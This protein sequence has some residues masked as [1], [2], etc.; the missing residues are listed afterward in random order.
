MR[1]RRAVDGDWRA[2]RE[3]RLEAL[4][5]APLAFASTYAREAAFSDEVWRGRIAG[6]AQFL[7]LVGDE[8]VGTATGY[9]DE[10]D[11]H[12]VRLV[13]MYVRPEHRGQGYAVQLLDGVVADARARGFD[14]VLLD[15]VDTNTPARWCYLRY[16]FRPTG[17][18]APLPH[19]PQHTETEMVLT[20]RR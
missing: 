9:V 7:A 20:L 19:A 4:Q 1:V 5:E 13:A 10:S 18:V 8:V 14:R 12:T 11:P 16:G 3:L 2:V 6:A 15:V 17:V